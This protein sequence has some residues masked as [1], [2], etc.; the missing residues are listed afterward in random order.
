MGPSDATDSSPSERFD[1]PADSTA[2]TIAR[3]H[4]QH[5]LRRWGKQALLEPLTLVVSELVGNAVRHGRPPYELLLRKTGRGVRADVHDDAPEVLPDLSQDDPASAGHDAESGRG[6]LMVHA[7]TTHAV[8]IVLA[9]LLLIG[10]VIGA[11]FGAILTTRINQLTDH[12]KMHAKDNHSRRGLLMM[13][14]KRRSLLDYLK[15]KD[16]QRYSDL[17]AKLG[18]RK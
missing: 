18:L 11:Q 8:D 6:L 2:A 5:L 10:G 13:V 17:I 14:N 4:V 15:K 12:F 3:G 9:G 1:L 7:M 16:V